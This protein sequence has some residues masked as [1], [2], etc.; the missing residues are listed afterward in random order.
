MNRTLFPRYA[1]G[2]L[3]Y[4]LIVI[5]WGAIV[6]AT[7]SGA[8]CGSHWPLCN[9]QAIPNFQHFHTVIEFTH[10]ISTGLVIPLVIV[11]L[12]WALRVYPQGHPAR[13]GAKLA[14]LFT[15]SEALLGAGLVLFKLVEHN[16]SVQRAVAMSAHLTNT[17]L[18]VGVLTLTAWWGQGGKPVRL[19]QGTLSLA[20]GMGIGAVILVAVSGAIA[21]LGDT[22][23][24]ARDLF[25]AIRQ[26]MSPTAHFLI[27]LRL[28][29]PM[30]AVTTG[31]YL[32]LLAATLRRTRPGETGRMALRL[33]ILFP[34]QLALG[35]TNVLLLA[36]IWLQVVHLLVSD[37]TWIVLILMA[38]STLSEPATESEKERIRSQEDLIPGILPDA[39]V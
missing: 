11:L 15:F 33:M 14:V 34:A 38:A 20:L 19:R 10:R 22:L 31:I 4:N 36:P 32:L 17:L 18:L 16:A 23:Y 39:P 12:V 8:G 13:L 2:L 21:A 30:L 3:V 25:E 27:R 28:L 9:G 35:L 6:R 24:P 7:G 26:D 5:L 29:H 1:W 37:L